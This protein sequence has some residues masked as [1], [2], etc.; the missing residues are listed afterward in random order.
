MVK[1]PNRIESNADPFTYDGANSISYNHIHDHMLVLG[2]GGAIYTLGAQGNLPFEM[3]SK[4][5]NVSAILPPSMQQGNWIHDSGTEAT[6]ARDHGGIGEGCHCPGALYSDEGST[7]WNITGNVVERVADWLQG[8]RPGCPWIG[9]NWQNHNWFDVASN[10]TV[11]VEARC[12]LVADVQVGGEGAGAQ[13]PAAAAA[14]MA[15][16][17]PRPPAV[18]HV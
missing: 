2:D 18:V 10:R 11:N 15:A 8:C 7:N 6:A 9:P 12:P 13:W 3:P 1:K 17:G 16:A 14:V 4:Y 5:K